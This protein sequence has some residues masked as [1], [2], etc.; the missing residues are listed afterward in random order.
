MSHQAERTAVDPMKRDQQ[1]EEMV[2]VVCIVAGLVAVGVAAWMY[3]RRRE[4]RLAGLER[5]EIPIHS[6][7][8]TLLVLF[9]AIAA[10]PVLVGVVGA[11][12]DPWLREHALAAVITS[13]GGGGLSLV[14]AMAATKRFRTT[15][16]L[17]LSPEILQLD[18]R[19]Q[20]YVLDPR[21]PFRLYEGSSIRPGS[22]PLQVVLVEQDGRSWGFSYG[23][24]L[25]R[26]SYSDRLTDALGPLLGGET[27]VLH[28][29]LRALP[30]V[31]RQD[32]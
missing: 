10:V 28:D 1:G 22:I 4:R 32:G 26:K 16:R 20:R 21:R 29:R 13:L 2:L 24:A 5:I 3:Q 27:R 31:K 12:T 17:I 7:A 8:R 14:L 30:T 11:M 18:D 15:G 6:I 23:L 19:G 9:P 25:G